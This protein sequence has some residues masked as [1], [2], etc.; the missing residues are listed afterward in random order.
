VPRPSRPSAGCSTQGNSVTY[1]YGPDE[2]GHLIGVITPAPLEA[3]CNKQ[4]TREVMNPPSSGR[5]S[6]TILQCDEIFIKYKFRRPVVDRDEL[7][8]RIINAAG[9]RG[10]Q[11][12]SRAHEALGRTRKNRRTVNT[13]GWRVRWK[14]V[15]CSFWPW[16]VPGI[17]TSN[18]DMTP[19]IATYSMAVRSSGIACSGPSSP[20][21]S[22]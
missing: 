1:I 11:V 20:S 6:R 4:E 21:W 3:L 15:L 16:P 22:P 18:V 9:H 8:P 7:H 12:K 13:S 17:I 2:M 19:G 10:G 5:P 14:G